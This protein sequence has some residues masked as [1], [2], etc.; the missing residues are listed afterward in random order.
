MVKRKIAS[1]RSMAVLSLS[2][3]ICFSLPLYSMAYEFSDLSGTWR[4]ADLYIHPSF[5]YMGLTK[6]SG[7]FGGT[8]SVTEM[9]NDGSTDVY[10]ISVGASITSDGLVTI[11]PAGSPSFQ[12]YMNASKDVIVTANNDDEAFDFDVI[13]KKASYYSSSDLSGAWYISSLWIDPDFRYMGSTKGSGSFGGSFS[14]TQTEDDE[15]P[16]T[17]TISVGA[18]ITS[19]GLVTIEPQGVTPFQGYMNASKDV[20]VSAN[21]DNG[22]FDFDVII[23]KADSYSSSD[24]SGTWRVAGLS[25]GTYLQWLGLTNGFGSFGEAFSVSEVDSNDDT[26]TYSIN[27]AATI[28]PGGLVTITPEGE[29]SFQGYMN[30]SKDMIVRLDRAGGGFNFEIIVKEETPPLAPVAANF[31]FVPTTGTSPLTVKFSDTSTGEITS[32]SW[33]FGDGST[34]KNR[35]PSHTYTKPGTYTVTLTVSGPAGT[36]TKKMANCIEVKSGAMPHLMLLLD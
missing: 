3:I 34:S 2:W 28:T 27:V 17:S 21:R 1:I 26:D 16:E 31:A 30:A 11:S 10:N 19:G 6:G 23:K 18:T 4:I 13:V 25:I 12:G 9:E 7:S 35:N 22:D 8:F 32:W 20:I 33:N 36:N 15:K 24:L 5:N 14:I 29:A